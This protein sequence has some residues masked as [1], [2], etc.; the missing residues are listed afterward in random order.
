MIAGP[1]FFQTWNS[2]IFDNISRF[3]VTI[4]SS[5]KAFFSPLTTYEASISCLLQIPYLSPDLLVLQ[6][7]GIRECE[8][9]QYRDHIHR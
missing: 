8:P 2:Y 5:A 1:D 7:R 6:H 9:T 4:S 3:G